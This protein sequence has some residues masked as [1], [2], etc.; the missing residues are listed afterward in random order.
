[1]SLEKEKVIL[2]L[3][4]K[5]ENLKR[6]LQEEKKFGRFMQCLFVLSWAITIV[7]V[8][9]LLFKLNCNYSCIQ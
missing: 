9:M 5:S 6:K 2:E 3:I 7:L 8:F 1:M 4:K